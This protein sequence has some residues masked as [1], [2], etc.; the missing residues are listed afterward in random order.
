MLKKLDEEVDDAEEHAI[1]KYQIEATYAAKISALKRKQ[2]QEEHETAM[3]RLKGLQT[4]IEG[5][6]GLSEEDKNKQLIPV[7]EQQLTL[8]TDMRTQQQALAN[9]PS[10]NDET[11]LAAQ[12]EFV[13]LDVQRLAL[14]R[15]MA[16]A[17]KTQTWGGQITARI[18]QMSQA[19]K[20]F[21]NHG[22]RRGFGA[23]Q[24]AVNQVSSA[25]ASAI[26]GTKSW[27][28]AFKQ[29][30]AGI[31]ETLVQILVQWV[32]NE[33]VIAALKAVFGEEDNQQAAD[34]AAAWAPAAVA[35]SIASYGAAAAVGLAAFV[36]AMGT[37]VG[38]AAAFSGGAGAGYAEGG[39]TGPGGKYEPAGIVHRGE[40]VI[41]RDILD[42]LGVGFFDDLH[43]MQ[44]G[45]Y[46]AISGG[47]GSRGGRR[48]SGAAVGGSGVNVEGHKLSVAIMH[49]KQQ[50]KEFM[51]S[52][53]GKAI[54][55]Q[56]VRNAKV[57]IGLQT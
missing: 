34:S 28:Q 38:L 1:L 36:A 44:Q 33:T 4:G 30:G 26:V 6:P 37:G 41:N 32:L 31:L 19:A 12:K 21:Q 57:Q 46:A 29:V 48:G 10:A 16:A 35:A 14:M 52:A 25:I 11:K 40:Y 7:Y 55:V 9:D 51:Q 15:Q 45:S 18:Q 47:A 3:E 43:N 23:L 24:T 17:E 20:E 5:T 39:Y 8:L 13:K 22:Y 49:S 27:G 54:V 53:E 56:H 2:V 50:L 42:N